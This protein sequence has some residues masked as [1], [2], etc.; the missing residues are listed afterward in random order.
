MLYISL[1]NDRYRTV[2]RIM[3]GSWMESICQLVFIW[4]RFNC[5]TVK[6]LC[7]PKN[8]YFKIH[9]VYLFFHFLTFTRVNVCCEWWKGQS[10]KPEPLRLNAVRRSISKDLAR[11]CCNFP[12]RKGGTIFK[13]FPCTKTCSL[14]VIKGVIKNV[15]KS[16]F[17]S[18][19]IM[20]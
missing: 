3:K 9:K 11:I 20:R 4:L 14:K 2:N 18:C 13:L 15:I 6:V 8:C 1:F 5:Y 16:Y 12:N 10:Q 7:L 19:L 17:Q